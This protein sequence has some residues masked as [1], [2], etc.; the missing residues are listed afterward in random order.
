MNP[1][2][3]LESDASHTSYSS[4]SD[5]DEALMMPSYNLSERMMKKSCPSLEKTDSGVTIMK[6]K[7]SLFNCKYML[8]IVNNYNI[9]S[10]N[11]IN[12]KLKL[13]ILSSY[14]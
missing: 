7:D 2:I 10:V 5:R 4:A 14:E 9:E 11:I 1:Y 12:Q 13:F 3:P 8:Y 6:G